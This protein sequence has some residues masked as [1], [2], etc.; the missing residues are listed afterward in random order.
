[1]GLLLTDAERRRFREWLLQ[2][3]ASAQLLAEQLRKV[4]LVGVAQQYEAEMA[5]ARLLARK[6]EQTESQTLIP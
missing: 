5:A 4:L 1:M 3:A 2:E 6:L